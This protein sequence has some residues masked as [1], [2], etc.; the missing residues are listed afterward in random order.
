MLVADGRTEMWTAFGIFLGTAF[1]LA[2]WN[3]G[4]NNWRWMLGVSETS[5][6]AVPTALTGMT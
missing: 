5:V 3:A 4:E 2:V 6:F 1:N